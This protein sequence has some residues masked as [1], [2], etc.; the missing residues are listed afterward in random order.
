MDRGAWRVPGRRVTKS[1]TQLKRLS[2][3]HTEVAWISGAVWMQGLQ[4]V[5][6][7]GCCCSSRRKQH[8]CGAQLPQPRGR[9]GSSYTVCNIRAKCSVRSWGICLTPLALQGC[10]KGATV[11]RPLPASL[12]GGLGMSGLWRE[13]GWSLAQ[14]TS[15]CLCLAALTTD[16]THQ[17]LF[18][19]ALSA[20]PDRSLSVC[21]EQHCKLLPG[22]AGISASTVAKWTIDEVRGRDPSLFLCP[23]FA[24]T[25]P[26]QEG[27]GKGPVRWCPI[28]LLTHHPSIHSLSQL[29]SGA[30]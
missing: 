16:V 29:P 15:L 7:P 22:V 10:L 28:P 14:A 30:A 18:M 4:R 11:R 21:W 5:L 17:S 24:F 19:S 12:P 6:F 3:Q 2:T 26:W 9:V 27:S 13:A 23:S 1:R 20:H 25:A 8:P